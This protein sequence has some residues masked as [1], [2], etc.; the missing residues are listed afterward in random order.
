MNTFKAVFFLSTQGTKRTEK[1]LKNILKLLADCTV[2]G[3][4][5]MDAL[6]VIHVLVITS[7]V[8]CSAGSS[9]DEAP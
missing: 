8:N 4:V 6:K 3:N 5:K 1:P 2:H 7:G 9:C